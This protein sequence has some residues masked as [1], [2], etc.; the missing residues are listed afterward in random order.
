MSSSLV[1]NQSCFVSLLKDIKTFASNPVTLN[2]L[3]NLRRIDFKKSIF[4]WF[5]RSYDSCFSRNEKKFVIINVD[6][7]SYDLL[8]SWI[9]CTT[10]FQWTHYLAF[11]SDRLSVEWKRIEE[12]INGPYNNVYYKTVK[13]MACRVE[14]RNH[15]VCLTDRIIGAVAKDDHQKMTNKILC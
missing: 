11:H 6:R 2:V 10:A 4:N 15:L 7:K 1:K 8:E 14:V 13:A 5:L 9:W 12:D 3:F